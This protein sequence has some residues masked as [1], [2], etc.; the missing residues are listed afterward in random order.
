MTSSTLETFRTEISSA[1]GPW[2]VSGEELAE[3]YGLTPLAP[4]D[5]VDPKTH[6]EAMVLFSHDGGEFK[7]PLWYYIL[8]EAEK[9][10]GHSWV[11]WEAVSS[12]K[13]WLAGSTMAMNSVSTIN[14]SRQSR[15]PIKSR[16]AI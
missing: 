10:G 5:V 4:A 9:G 6:P 13:S 15:I 11:R 1:A 3:F 8:K 14:G 7:T 2:I 16:F 12:P